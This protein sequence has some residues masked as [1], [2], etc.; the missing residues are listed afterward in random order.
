MLSIAS[1]FLVFCVILLQSASAFFEQG[2]VH[3]ANHLFN[4]VHSSMRQWGSSLNHNG[5]SFF[6]AYVPS[7]THLYHGSWSSELVRGTEWLAFEPEHSLIFAKPRRR[8]SRSHHDHEKLIGA[9]APEEHASVGY[10][11]TY[12][13]S[14][15][16]R[17]LYIDGLS[18]G[19]TNNGT[20]DTQDLLLL[21]FTSQDPH[22]PMGREYARARGLCDMASTVW[23]GRIDGILRMEG[24]F[25]II[26]CDFEK[27]LSRT[28][29]VPIKARDGAV[30]SQKFPGGW[31]YL[32]AIA[33]RYRGIGGGRVMVEYNSMVSVFA[34]ANN[35]ELFDNDVQSDYAMPRLQNVKA[36][37]LLQVKDDLTKVIRWGSGWFKDD[38]QAVADLV[39]TR[40]SKPLHYLHTNDRIR[41]NLETT[42][43]YIAKLLR[44]FIDYTARNT[45]LETT[46]CVGQMF[47]GFPQITYYALA[48]LAI[49]TVT[50]RICHTLLE[51][52]ETVS[53]ELTP[54]PGNLARAIKLIDD[55]VD[56]LQWTTWKSCGTCPDEEICY[57]PI[58][59]MGTHED[60]AYP[61]CLNEEKTQ[62]RWGYW[63]MP[64]RGPPREVAEERRK[65]FG[66][67][68]S[69]AILEKGREEYDE[70]HRQGEDVLGASPT[71]SSEDTQTEMLW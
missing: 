46:R 23:E 41:E 26:L 62:D 45:T 64:G 60:H 40:Y 12:T 8:L 22:G 61:S 34:H 3:N 18:A 4:A 58:W 37:D 36:T 53:S 30:G 52:L 27:N 66:M 25:E 21:N 38:W 32:K 24:G 6:L 70:V 59:P 69:S 55:L 7:G 13:V 10:L 28:D 48:P 39:V 51:S 47:Q 29:V 56:Y 35:T 33:A 44:P 15:G 63:G 49:Y 2:Q 31:P 9:S 20:L 68:P 67:Y 42:E 43:D 5:M 11:H 71:L 19:K 65:Q 14:N 1:I 17:L 57:L 16:L 50:T 54:T